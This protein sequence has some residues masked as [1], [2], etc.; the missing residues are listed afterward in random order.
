MGVCVT[1]AV[2]WA[3]VLQRGLPAEKGSFMRRCRM[4]MTSNS[5]TS[6]SNRATMSGSCNKRAGSVGQTKASTTRGGGDVVQLYCYGG[7]GGGGE[8]AV[9]EAERML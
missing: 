4:G 2:R 1:A 8:E 6:L 9:Q 3:F 5:T 7:W